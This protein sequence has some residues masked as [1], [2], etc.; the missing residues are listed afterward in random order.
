MGRPKGSKNKKQ[1]DDV[2]IPYTEKPALVVP[3]PVNVDVALNDLEKELT[4]QDET[5]IEEMREVKVAFL[6]Q[7]I[8]WPGIA[9]AE[10]TISQA[11]I[12]GVK[13]YWAFDALVLERKGQTCIVPHANVANA[14]LL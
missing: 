12:P 5:N 9:G 7:A 6:H 14:I 10:R 3:V 8:T 2:F 11:K 4:M 13:I 1:P